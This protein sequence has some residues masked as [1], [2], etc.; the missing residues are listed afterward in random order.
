MVLLPFNINRWRRIWL[1]NSI[2]NTKRNARR[3]NPSDMTKTT[4]RT[5]LNNVMELKDGTWSYNEK[6]VWSKWIPD[7]NSQPSPFVK[8]IQPHLGDDLNR[9][10]GSSECEITSDKPRDKESIQ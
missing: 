8:V 6:L 4:I 10:N 3:R 9:C 5:V 7:T 2:A 1:I